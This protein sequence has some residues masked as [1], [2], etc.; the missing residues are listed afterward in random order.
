MELWR[1]WIIKET[2]LHLDKYYRDYK[3]LK[4]MDSRLKE[5]EVAET[6]A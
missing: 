1:T 6:M 2:T 5:T 3:N 4:Q